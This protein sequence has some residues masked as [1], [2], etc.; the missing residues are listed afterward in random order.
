MRCVGYQ[1]PNNVYIIYLEI[2]ETEIYVYDL[3]IANKINLHIYNYQRELKQFGA[4]QNSN[5]EKYFQSSK[6]CQKCCDY[7]NEKYGMMLKLIKG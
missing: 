3:S 1:K 2:S 6:K 5:R 7:L 4:I